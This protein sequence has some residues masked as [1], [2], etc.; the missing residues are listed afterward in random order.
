[1]DLGGTQVTYSTGSAGGKVRE[2]TRG[3]NEMSTREMVVI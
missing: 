2:A 1:M 3:V